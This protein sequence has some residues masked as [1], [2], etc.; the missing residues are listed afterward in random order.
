M[1]TPIRVKDEVSTLRH[2]ADTLIQDITKLSA[3]LSSAGLEA[4]EEKGSQIANSIQAQLT[5]LRK[6][7]AGLNEVMKEYSENMDHAVR[8]NPYTYLFGALGIG[9]LLGKL[10]LGNSR[11]KGSSN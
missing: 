3:M 4:A 6:R 9:Y 7:V 11:S 5:E 1:P 2:D 8:S 10:P